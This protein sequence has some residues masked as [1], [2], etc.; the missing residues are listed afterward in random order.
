METKDWI[1]LIVPIVANGFIIFVFQKLF[2]KR[3]KKLTKRQDIR[4]DVLH[5]FWKK[6]QSLNELFLQLNIQSRNDPSIVA[7]SIS[8][9][10]PKVLEI[11]QYYDT[12]KYDLEIFERKFI[13]LQNSWNEFNS[14][15]C[16]YANHTLTAE[17]QA[18][19]GHKLQLVK[20]ANLELITEVRKKY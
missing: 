19:L 8:F 10:G 1:T 3:L 7:N 17:M 13:I 18:N 16:S 9:F 15:W 2:E 20:S 4:D 6:L 5:T 11:V 14:T 12:N